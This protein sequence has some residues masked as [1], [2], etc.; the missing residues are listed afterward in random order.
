MVGIMHALIILGVTFD[1]DD[2]RSMNKVLKIVLVTTPD[3]NRPDKADFLAQENKMGSGKGEKKAINQQQTARRPSLK[4]ALSESQKAQKA[5]AQAQKVLLQTQADVAID[6]CNKKV[7]EKSEAEITADL[8]CLSEEIAKLQAKIDKAEEN[9]KL[10]AEID[11]IDKA[12]ASYS[13]QPRKM[14]IDSINAHKYKA[15]SYEAA[16]ERKIESIGNLNYPS[17]M[18]RK[19]LSGTLMMDVEIRADGSLVK[20]TITHRSGHKIIDDAALNIVKLAAP[21][22]ALPLDLQKEVDILVITRAWQF[23]NEG[24]LQTQSQ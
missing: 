17:D 23:S 4:S 19:K 11:K 13:K 6:V 5:K 20:A 2:G 14:P 1:V 21:F 8:L 7:A 3:K 10:Q 18:R 22:A 12:I 24:S 15:A 9:A 16:W